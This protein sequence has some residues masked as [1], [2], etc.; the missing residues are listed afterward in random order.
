VSAASLPDFKAPPVW[1]VVLS[2]QFNDLAV[3][4]LLLTAMWQHFRERFPRVEEQP[5]LPSQTEKY[6]APIEQNV[7]VQ[8]LTGR[9]LQPRYWFVSESGNE[10]VQIQTDRFIFNWR[11]ISDEDTYPR[12]Q[13]VRQRLVDELEAFR[14]FVGE[15]QLGEIS[16]N[17]CEATYINHIRPRSD[18]SSPADISRIFSFISEPPESLRELEAASVALQ[19]L[20]VDHD[21]SPIGR[22]YVNAQSALRASDQA[23]VFV[24]NLLA[25]GA[26]SSPEFV[27]ALALLDVQHEWVVR[28]FAELTTPEMHEVWQRSDV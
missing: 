15:E 10:L 14:R 1:E 11:K 6:D 12:Y 17:Q 24:L 21:G 13:Y 20:K 26:P 27:D 18:W 16:F 5:P 22:F 25:R 9:V 7:R 8:F 28:A 2:L 23:D 19:T 4:S 3:T